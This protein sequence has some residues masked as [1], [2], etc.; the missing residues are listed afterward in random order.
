MRLGKIV[1]LDGRSYRSLL[2]G[3]P[4]NGIA[5]GRTYDAVIAACALKVKG[6]TLLTFNASHFSSFAARGLE[7]IVP[8]G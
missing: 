4:E 1:A 6:A 5:G 3:A 2:R 8:G 7:V